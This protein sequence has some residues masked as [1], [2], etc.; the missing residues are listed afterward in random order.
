[1]TPVDPNQKPDAATLEPRLAQRR[2]ELL[3]RIE[4]GRRQLDEGD[5]VEYD[6]QSLAQRFGELKG[7]AAKRSGNGM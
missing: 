5:Y 4:I 6:E 7:R 2:H 1:M 3:E